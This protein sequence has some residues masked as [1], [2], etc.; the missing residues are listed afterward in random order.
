MLSAREAA[1]RRLLATA[2]QSDASKLFATS[3][4]RQD[5]DDEDSA[6]QRYDE[7]IFNQVIIVLIKVHC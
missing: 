3:V 5:S 6:V 7:Q 1:S 2:P 4:M